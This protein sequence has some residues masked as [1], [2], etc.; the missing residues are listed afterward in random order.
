MHHL[1]F[2]IF[3]QHKSVV[4]F[5]PTNPVGPSMA[6]IYTHNPNKP[7]IFQY[8]VS[9]IIQAFHSLDIHLFSS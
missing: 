8:E 5:H 9:F 4:S 3:N 1:H 7:V 6:K 2:I